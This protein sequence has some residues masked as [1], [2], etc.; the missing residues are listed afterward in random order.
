[1]IVCST[2]ENNN[3]PKIGFK[4]ICTKLRKFYICLLERTVN[5]TDCFLFCA[6]CSGIADIDKGIS[7]CIFLNLNWTIVGMVFQPHLNQGAN[8]CCA[9]LWMTCRTVM[10]IAGVLSDE[11]FDF[12]S[13][14]VPCPISHD[15]R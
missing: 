15:D 13:V 9:S 10:T 4:E 14:R 6:P 7:A 12:D 1:M 3:A 2:V 8:H 11:Y 5:I